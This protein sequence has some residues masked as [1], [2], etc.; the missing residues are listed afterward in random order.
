[1]TIIEGKSSTGLSGSR[2]GK[3]LDVIDLL[4]RVNFVA[5]RLKKSGELGQRNEHLLI[6][7]LFH[8]L[9]FFESG[10]RIELPKMILRRDAP[11]RQRNG[12]TVRLHA[13]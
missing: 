9:V 11:P 10:K 12:E 3:E 13:R 4:Y 1:M 6:R 2:S 8:S 5:E 7:S